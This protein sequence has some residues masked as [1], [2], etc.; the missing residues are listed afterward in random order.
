MLSVG[1]KPRTAEFYETLLR[2]HALPTLGRRSAQT[3]S[4]IAELHSA[5]A[6]TPHNANRLVAAVGSLYSYASKHGLLS[7]G[8]AATASE[9]GATLMQMFKRGG[10]LTRPQHARHKTNDNKR[11]TGV[12]IMREMFANQQLLVAS[13]LEE[14]WL[15]YLNYH[16]KEGK[17]VQSFCDLLDSTR[18]AITDIRF[19]KALSEYDEMRYGRDFGSGA[20]D[21][22]CKYP[23]YGWVLHLA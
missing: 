20:A 23:D 11:A 15:E 4:D 2:K 10:V 14:W 6:K 17:I 7:E 13:C 9:D 18:T 22:G 5:M 19:A 16:R 3:K 8:A 21:K 1:E 12:S